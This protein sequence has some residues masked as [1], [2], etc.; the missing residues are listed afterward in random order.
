MSFDNTFTVVELGAIV[1]VLWE[2]L[3]GLK[4]GF[5]GELSRLIS[6]TIALV[7]GLRF[8]QTVGR[9]LVDNTRL[10]EDPELALA[11][12]FLLIVACVALLFIVLR[13]ILRLLMT[14]KFN[15][16]ID[17]SGGGVAGLLRGMLMALLCVYA[18]G[19]WP[20]EYLQNMVRKQSS[21]GRMVFRY[22]PTVIGKLN[23][24]RWLDVGVKPPALTPVAPQPVEVAP[25]KQES[26]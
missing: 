10:S 20:H 24:I 11:V 17:R 2:L 4:R 9:L 3:W 1:L 25:P 5:A 22:A 6:T 8:H 14:V 7:A 12:A 21:V 15:D 26:K 13:L 16:K 23:A 19:L 18:I